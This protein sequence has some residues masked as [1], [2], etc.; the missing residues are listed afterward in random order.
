RAARRDN[1]YAP[2]RSHAEIARLQEA[3]KPWCQAMRTA[4]AL[5]NTLT[6]PIGSILRHRETTKKPAAP[7][8]QKVN[9][10]KELGSALRETGISAGSLSLP[11]PPW[12]RTAKAC[13]PPLPPVDKALRK[14]VSWSDARLVG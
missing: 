11:V 10:T 2:D 1:S 9:R 14:S 5:C 12:K 4:N 7:S 13:C 6:V 3:T 8:A